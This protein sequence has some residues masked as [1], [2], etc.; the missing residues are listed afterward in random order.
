MAVVLGV[1]LGT[2]TI[3]ALAMDTDTGAV[4][5]R[6]TIANDT[7]II[8][9]ERR[10]RGFSEWNGRA[11]AER[12]F[13]S[14]RAVADQLGD[15]CRTLAGIGIT[16]QQHG[17]LLVDKALT[18]LTPFINWQDRRGEEVFPGRKQTFVRE[19]VQ[20]LGEDGPR[21]AG[22]RLATG[23]MA[24][25]LFWLSEHKL[26]PNAGTACF[27]MDYFAALLTGEQPATDPTC[28]A[29]SGV[30]HV[31][32][33]QWDATALAALGLAPSL[34]PTVRRSGELLGN[35][36]PQMADATGLPK[37]LPVFVGI[38]D[39]Q[40]SF[41]GSVASREDAVLVNVGTGGQVA[42]Y[43]PNFI[44]DPLLETRP[45]PGQG[46]LLVSAGLC[47]GGSYALLERFYREVGDRLFHV[48]HEKTL[49]DAMNQLAAG[50]PQGADGLHCE[51]FFAGTRLQPELRASF[52]GISAENFTPAHVT[53]ALLEG[54]ARSL[55]GGYEKIT[56]LI[57]TARTH[58]VG[59]GNG[60]RE[61]PVFAR[62]LAEE[63]GLQV[64]FAAHREE[65]AYGAA[66]LAAVGANLFPDLD[67]AG[68]LIQYPAAAE[69]SALN[70]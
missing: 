20:R 65:A 9:P 34:F 16:G 21:R 60:L 64:R 35:L 38:G 33:Q 29:S 50:I 19:A 51:P 28:A 48:E 67:A 63:F 49:Y 55:R 23:Y 68:N 44:Y 18:A 47:G 59:S 56:H 11:L 70:G 37:G 61:N 54:M 4:R 39:N 7:Q 31:A 30:L 27:L 36:T 57:G 32:L 45:Y 14:L 2:T 62:I 46:Y 66:L 40:A 53:R 17:V 58:L 69:A 42:G 13:S 52:T 5:A 26:L 12:G 24:L 25:T 15:E 3:T 8:D 1:D 22:C 43:A 6:C 41:L 10:A